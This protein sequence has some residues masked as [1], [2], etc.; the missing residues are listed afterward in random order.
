MVRRS[1]L[2]RVLTDAA[3]AHGV[4]VQCGR[5]LVDINRSDPSSVVARFA[6]GGCERG[7]LMIACDGIRS[8]VRRL[9]LPDSPAPAYSGL[10]DFGGIV[11]GVK[12]PLPPGINV[13]VFGRRAFFG[14]FKTPTGQVWWFQNSGEKRP[15][16]ALRESTALRAHLLEL[17]QDDPSWIR[18]LIESTETMLGPFPLND[19]LSMPRW[20]SGRI[21]LIGDAAHATTPSAGQGASL[22]LEDAMVLAQCIRDIDDPV[23]AFTAFERARRNRVE[24]IVKQSRRMGNTKAVSGPVAEWVRDRVLPFFLRLGARAQER[25][26]AYRLNWAQQYA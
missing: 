26:Y 12:V 16:A 11:D 21:C 17:H 20:H 23:R 5:T 1:D 15:E 22:A 10:L 18:A 14:G 24:E 9:A 8:T 6:D 2:H 13:M 4:E 25:H 3:R 19:V 7:D